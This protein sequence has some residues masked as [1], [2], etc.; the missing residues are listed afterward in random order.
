MFL[1]WAVYKKPD[2]SMTLNG[3]LAGLVG[4]TAG[5][6][7]VSPVGAIGLIC[8]VAVVFSIEFIDKIKLTILLELF[9][10]TVYVVP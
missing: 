5:C 1:T 2:I 8:G 6:A 7:A 10:Y 3:V 4:V 9:L